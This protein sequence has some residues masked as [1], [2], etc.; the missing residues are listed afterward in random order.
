[1]PHNMSQAGIQKSFTFDWNFIWWQRP[2]LKLNFLFACTVVYSRNYIWTSNWAT[3]SRIHTCYHWHR[4]SI[5]DRYVTWAITYQ[6]LKEELPDGDAE[7][8]VSGMYS[9]L[10]LNQCFKLSSFFL[11]NVTKVLN[12]HITG[13]SQQYTDGDFLFPSS[14]SSISSELSKWF[15]DVKLL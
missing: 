14:S 6:S 2:I 11:P 13:Y 9:L 7:N 15:W 4:R 1:M 12:L 3:T 8:Q 5:K 10:Y